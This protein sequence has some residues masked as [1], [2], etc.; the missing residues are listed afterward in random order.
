MITPRPR[1][2][3]V[4]TVAI[5]SALLSSSSVS[6]QDT[7]VPYDCAKISVAGNSYDISALKKTYLVKGEA[8]PVYPNKQQVNYFVN[9]CQAIVVPDGEAKQHCVSGAWVCQ[10]TK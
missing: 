1:T 10:E 3:I 5:I 6:A 8:T 2:A 4:A 9:P 7:P